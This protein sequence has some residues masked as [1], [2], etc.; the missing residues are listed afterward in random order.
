MHARK[1]PLVGAVVLAIIYLGVASA[2]VAQE[3]SQE[4]DSTDKE[5]EIKALRDRL[6]S[7]QRRLDSQIQEM[8]DVKAALEAAEAQA[9]AAK[10]QTAT[11]PAQV[12]SAVEAAKP[13]T[14][15]IYYKGVTITLGGFLAAEYA[16]RSIDTANDIATGYNQSYYRNDPLAHLSQ[17]VFSARQSTLSALLQADPGPQTHLSLFAQMDF[18]GAAQTADSVES[19]SYNP[20]LMQ[21]YG[22]MDW[23]D[24]HLHFLAGQAWS[25]VTLNRTGISPD[26][27]VIPPTID[28]QYMPGFAW[29][30]QPQIRLT[31][32]IDQD[33]WLALGLE[34]PQTTFYT[35]A[36]PLPATVNLNYQTSGTGLGYN[37]QDTFS[38][39][40]IPDAVLKLA[41][42]VTF[43]GRTLHVE[44]FGLYSSFYERL[45]YAGKSVSGGGAGAGLVV[46]LIPRWLDLQV[47][48][49]AGKGIGRYGSAQLADVTFDP[50]G[51]I[52][53]IRE[54]IAMAGLTVHAM[55]NLDVYVFAGQEKA[56]KQSFDLTTDPG[57]PP[58]IV[59]YGYGNPM[60]S[61]AGCVSEVVAVPAPCVA[62][63][64]L[65]EQ[66]TAG[67]WYQPYS[68]NFGTLRWGIQYS[69]T[70]IKAFAGVGGTPVA[71]FNSVFGSFRYYPFEQRATTR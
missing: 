23:D 43:L 8:Q 2:A 30:R 15:K 59:N 41:G 44:G 64:Q 51:T 62:N 55:R 27:V 67:F 1:S 10:A 32:D 66:G 45:N 42:D 69:R 20:R 61:N 50:T 28:G 25:L 17:S 63:E 47:S 22:A 3:A 6:D 16:H 5:Q 39:N 26:S 29:A 36:N 19:N 68:G 12:K 33:F 53:P 38:L 24:L 46:P 40:H 54:L 4:Q 71:T 49:L 7:L 57:P 34:S 56:S 14:D 35:G 31:Q 48:G 18:Q 58:V 9:A 13:K 37:T 52:Q 60:Y 11:I 70:E 21:M 65:A